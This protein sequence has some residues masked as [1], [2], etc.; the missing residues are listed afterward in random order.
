MRWSSKTYTRNA[1]GFR[2]C[3][4]LGPRRYLKCCSQDLILKYLV[5]IYST[6]RLAG[7]EEFC[8][9]LVFAIARL[10]QSSCWIL[11]VNFLLWIYKNFTIKRIVLLSEVLSWFSSLNQS[12]LRTVLWGWGWIRVESAGGQ[13]SAGCYQVVPDC[14]ELQDT[15]LHLMP[16]CCQGLDL[17]FNKYILFNQYQQTYTSGETFLFFANILVGK[18]N[19]EIYLT[20]TQSTF[21]QEN[22]DTIHCRSVSDLTR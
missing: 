20:F 16:W 5:Q 11:T 17:E 12:S 18:M 14:L 19:R 13:C 8:K 3:L 6:N 15:P 1:N 10:L 2:L 22:L 21:Y 9:M 7:E 4:M